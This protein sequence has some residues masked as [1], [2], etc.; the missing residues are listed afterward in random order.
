MR[1]SVA[2][3]ALQLRRYRS[4]INRPLRS[5]ATISPA[6]RPD[7]VSTAPF[8]L[9]STIP[10]PPRPIAAP[11]R[12][13]HLPAPPPP[14]PKTPLTRGRRRVVADGAKKIGSRGAKGKPIAYPAD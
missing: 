8:W 13:A 11:A 12:T 2:G 6:C 14:P 3:H 9:V 1:F 10:P 5:A 7:R 4:V